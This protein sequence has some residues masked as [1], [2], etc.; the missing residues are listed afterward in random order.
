MIGFFNKFISGKELIDGNKDECIFLLKFLL[1]ACFFPE[2]Q[3]IARMLKNKFNKEFELKLSLLI[4][5][6]LLKSFQLFEVEEG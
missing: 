3:M 6:L 2:G 1:A 4:K 5:L